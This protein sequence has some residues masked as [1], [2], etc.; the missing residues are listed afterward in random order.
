MSQLLGRSIAS[1]YAHL[2]RKQF[3]AV[4]MPIKLGRRLAWVV[5]DV[6]KW[7]DDKL[8][9]VHAEHEAYKK[10]IQTHPRRR[11]RPTKAEGKLKIY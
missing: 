10:S 2:Q 8:K 11:G 1:I 7:V 3:D 4:P 9:E 5:A 6:N